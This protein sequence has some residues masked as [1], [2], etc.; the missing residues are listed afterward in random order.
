MN[1]KLASK[2]YV[3]N[4]DKHHMTVEG[5]LHFLKGNQKP[6]FSLTCVVSRVTPTGRW[7]DDMCGAAHGEIS[8]HFPKFDD[9]AAMHL[10]D[11][12]GV[13]LHAVAN[14]W[15]WLAGAVEGH[16]GER[17]HGG[18]SKMQHWGEDEQFDGYR[19]S[20][21][22]E[23]LSILARHLR[24]D[25]SEAERL[26]EEIQFRNVEKD[27]ED[28]YTTEELMKAVGAERAR[29]KKQFAD[30]VEAQKPRWKRE[31]QACI[32][33]HGLKIYGDKWEG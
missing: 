8:K 30:Y 15:Y 13:P 2:T 22:D 5:G 20:T 12:D 28:G 23:C 1:P 31:A 29:V 10:S 19:V 14:G 26:S 27:F 3:E 25:K 21:R 6:H 11:M 16:F 32:E 18:N 9:L 17:Y 24:I 4:G 33:K 7:V